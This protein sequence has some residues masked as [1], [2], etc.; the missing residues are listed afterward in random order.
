MNKR[1]HVTHTILMHFLLNH[2][3][4]NVGLTDEET[5]RREASGYGPKETSGY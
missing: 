4:A 5:A 2:L 1:S 3:M